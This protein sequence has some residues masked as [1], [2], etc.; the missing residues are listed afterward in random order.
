MHAFQVTHPAAIRRPFI[1]PVLLERTL[2]I[3]AFLCFVGHG[4]FGIITK[5]AWVPYFGVV[6]IGSNTAY[7]LMPLI[8]LL[9]I[10]MGCVMLLTPRPVVVYWMVAWAAWTAL[11]RPL[12]GES[13]WEALERAGNFGVPAAVL[14]M[15]HQP[16][17]LG[18]A[19]RRL[20]FR[21]LD[22]SLLP[23]LQFVLLLTA[24]LLLAGHGALGL[25]GKPGLTANYAAVFPDNAAAIMTPVLGAFE[26]ALAVLL[27]RRPSV[28]LALF[29]ALWKL[30]TESLFL[31]AGAPFWEIVER[32]GS[33]AAPLA[34]AIVLSLRTSWEPAR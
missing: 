30:A 12:S 19:F 22:A 34:L 10:T 4:A 6:G 13:V 32:G 3:G 5:R 8:G 18:G 29:I 9:D 28:S 21:V 7:H 23:R 16:K 17:S 14:A 27:S 1:S 25:M 26:L 24:V 31:A 2:R 20:R 33:Y 11:L 15:I